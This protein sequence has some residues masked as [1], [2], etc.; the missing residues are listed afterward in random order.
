MAQTFVGHVNL[1]QFDRDASAPALAAARTLSC[2][3]SCPLY[4]HTNC[5]RI[6][7]LKRSACKGR[8]IVTVVYRCHVGDLFFSS[9]V[10]GE[11]KVRRVESVNEVRRSTDHTGLHYL[12]AGFETERFRYAL[13]Q[14]YAVITLP[15]L[16]HS[17]LFLVITVAPRQSCWGGPTQT[18]VLG[19]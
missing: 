4:I 6:I 3:T 9:S 7:R 13:G 11:H 16:D 1:P 19:S 10:H 8:A 14:L 12:N 2:D 18:F 5:S 17:G 15:Q